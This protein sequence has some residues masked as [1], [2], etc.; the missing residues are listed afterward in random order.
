MTCKKTNGV[1]QG[2][3]HYGVITTEPYY[4]LP[5]VHYSDDNPVIEPNHQEVKDGLS[6]TYSKLSTTKD[7][8]NIAVQ[9][10]SPVNII[11]SEAAFKHLNQL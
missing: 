1:D 9:Y 4:Q 5:K 6:K 8:V 10:S 11:I 7:T 2:G 3:N